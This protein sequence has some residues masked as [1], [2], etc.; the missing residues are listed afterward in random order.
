MFSASASEL[1]NVIATYRIVRYSSE[2]NTKVYGVW[3][4]PFKHLF[5][6]EGWAG[7]ATILK[8]QWRKK[9]QLIH[10]VSLMCV[11]DLLV[12][13]KNASVWARLS[14]K[15][16]DNTKA[17]MKKQ[18]QRIHSVFSYVR[19]RPFSFLRHSSQFLKHSVRKLLQPLFKSPFTEALTGVKSPPLFSAR[20]VF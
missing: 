3:T 10:S 4:H 9:I 7:L 8:T 5:F 19:P 2:P 1:G 16:S 13:L 11:H 17:W 20:L 15:A 6:S 14:G 18:I 12:F